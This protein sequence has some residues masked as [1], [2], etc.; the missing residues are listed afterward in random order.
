MNPDHLSN[1][2]PDCEF[3]ELLLESIDDGLSMLGDSTKQAVYVC[4]QKTYKIK[5]Q[6]IPNK[7]QRFTHAIERIFGPGAKLLQIQIM[8]QLYGRIRHDF[9]YFPENGELLFLEYVAAVE[10]SYVQARTQNRPVPLRLF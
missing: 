10:A 4:L 8:K 9:E 1:P 7:I 6:D 5:K 2:P 3:E